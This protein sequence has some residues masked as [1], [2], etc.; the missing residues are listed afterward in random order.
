M[1]LPREKAKCH[2]QILEGAGEGT[3]WLEVNLGNLRRLQGISQWVTQ[4][5]KATISSPAA[6]QAALS[7][8]S[9]AFVG[10]A[11]SRGPD[12]SCPKAAPVWER[13]PGFQ[14]W[15]G[16]GKVSGMPWAGQ[17]SKVGEGLTHTAKR[18]QARQ[19]NQP[20]PGPIPGY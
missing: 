17:W 8:P 2:H 11:K 1:P 20:T 5:P 6:A 9:S 3:V 16:L 4:N 14:C 18:S 19:G 10:K 15:Q 13:N 12:P 7:H